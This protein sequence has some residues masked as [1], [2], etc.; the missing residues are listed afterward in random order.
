MSQITNPMTDHEFDGIR[1][2]DNPTP[3]WWHFIFLAT[4]VF[5]WFY[6]V[7]YQFSPLASSEHDILAKQQAAEY[8]RIFGKLGDLKNDDAT[9]LKL[10]GMSD[11]MSIAQGM[12]ESTCA[13]CHGKEGGGINGVNLTD[14]H[15]KNVKKMTDIYTVITGGA[16][17]GAMPAWRTN[18]NEN[19]RILLASYIA[20]LRG[21][22]KPGRGQEGEVIAPWPTSSGSN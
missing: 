8:K 7:F 21:T 17:N 22:N 18:F 1:E 11:M 16:G 15:Y 20:T 12:F 14:N 4:V 6:F 2:Y 9:L 5:S 10:Q 3:G 19:E 13:Q